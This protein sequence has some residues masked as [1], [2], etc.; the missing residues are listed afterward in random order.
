MNRKNFHTVYYI[1]T[2]CRENIV[3]FMLNLKMGVF[4]LVGL[5]SVVH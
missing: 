5:V 4:A 3:S 2:L 1:N